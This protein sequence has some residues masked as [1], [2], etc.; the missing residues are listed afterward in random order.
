MNRA[1]VGNLDNFS[2][3]VEDDEENENHSSCK[4][5]E[6]RLVPCFFELKES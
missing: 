6:S 2:E 1:G 4:S 5:T 3:R